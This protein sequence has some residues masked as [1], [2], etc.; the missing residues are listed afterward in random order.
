MF[1]AEKLIEICVLR[2]NVKLLYYTDRKLTMLYDV[3]R[4]KCS[5]Y[6]LISVQF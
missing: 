6:H 2:M 3:I 1:L 5:K 4:N